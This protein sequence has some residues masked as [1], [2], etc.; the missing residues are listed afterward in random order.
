MSR[1]GNPSTL[2]APASY[3]DVETVALKSVGDDRVLDLTKIQTA[4][5]APLERLRQDDLL[6][7][8]INLRDARAKAVVDPPAFL[9]LALAAGEE[10]G[11]HR[12]PAAPAVALR[13]TRRTSL[14]RRLCAPTRVT[15]SFR[16]RDRDATA[17]GRGRDGCPNFPPF[18]PPIYSR[19]PSG[20]PAGTFA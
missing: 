12:R 10:A 16:S 15:G 13:G 9:R 19:P 6:M 2:Q 11:H 8:A 1:G 5:G 14:G 4:D 3:D 20:Q 7:L 17:P 18:H